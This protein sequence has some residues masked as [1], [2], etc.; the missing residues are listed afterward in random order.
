MDP[1]TTVNAGDTR[2]VV[3]VLGQP[4]KHR[5]FSDARNSHLQEG[6][7]VVVVERGPNPDG[8]IWF[9]RMPNGGTPQRFSDGEVYASREIWEDEERTDMEFLQWLIGDEFKLE[10]H[11]NQT[12]APYPFFI[13]RKR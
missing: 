13:I 3:S 7:F 2:F 11:L 4:S 8:C 6:D 10:R 9:K 12:G 1:L 5:M